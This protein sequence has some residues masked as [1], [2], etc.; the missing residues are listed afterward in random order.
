MQ[1]TGVYGSARFAALPCDDVFGALIREECTI[2]HHDDIRGGVCV[3]CV[4]GK[5]KLAPQ[6][7]QHVFQVL[8]GEDIVVIDIQCV[9]WFSESMLAA[10]GRVLTW[11]TNRTSVCHGSSE[12][13]SAAWWALHGWLAYN[14]DAVDIIH[15]HAVHAAASAHTFLTK[16]EQ[17]WKM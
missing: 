1:R 2:C 9:E 16:L 6:I 15:P 4:I 13:R 5:G 3:E 8:G 10:G 12:C 14:V 17:L 11:D 7:L